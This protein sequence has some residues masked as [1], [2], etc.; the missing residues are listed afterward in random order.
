MSADNNKPAGPSLEIDLCGIRMRSP[1]ITASGTFGY[2]FEAGRVAD[3]DFHS[4]GAV[5]LKSVTAQPR[6]GNRP[7]R[8]AE[9]PAGMLNSVGLQNPGVDYV[10]KTYLGMLKNFDTKFIASVAA[11]SV[12]EFALAS[13]KMAAHPGISAVEINMSCPNVKGG[14][15]F[16]SD[17]AEAARVVGAVKARIKKPLFA[18]LAPTPDGIQEMAQ[19]CIDAGANALTV[20][21]T[22]V[23]MAVD[24]HSR[25]PILG[26]NFGGLSGPAVKPLALYNVHLV[27][28]VASKARVPVIGCGGVA[29]ASDAAEMMLAGA[30]AVQVGTALFANLHVCRDICAGLRRYLAEQ[31]EKD[32]SAIVGAL[33]LN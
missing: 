6:E 14:R 21:N 33:K 15:H 28:Q 11:F 4:I 17:A 18:K 1:L 9:T 20:G 13:E 10:I 31:N 19:A 16:A 23:G 25:R 32:V 24:A 29:T 30:S 12:E 7:P 27:Y 2:A 26:N 3:F 22:F 8:V 5:C